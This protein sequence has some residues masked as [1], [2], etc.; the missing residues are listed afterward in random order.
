[1]QVYKSVKKIP[2]ATIQYIYE[3]QMNY[4]TYVM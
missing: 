1:M 4:C 3:M 2:E